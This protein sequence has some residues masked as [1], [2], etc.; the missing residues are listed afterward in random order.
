MPNANDRGRKPVVLLEDCCGECYNEDP[1]IISLFSRQ[2][3][4]G[5]KC[6][7]LGTERWLRC[8]ARAAG[9]VS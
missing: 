6:W 5:R 8:V 9:E 3:Y 4:C 7:V 2:R 1:K